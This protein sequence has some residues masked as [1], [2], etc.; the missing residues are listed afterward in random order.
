[1]AAVRTNDASRGVDGATNLVSNAR[2]SKND[3]ALFAAV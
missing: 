3:L 2:N 1:M